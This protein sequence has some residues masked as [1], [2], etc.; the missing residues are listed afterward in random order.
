LQNLSADS[1][2]VAVGAAPAGSPLVDILSDQ[3]VKISGG[4]ITLEPFQYLWLRRD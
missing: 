3:A 2:T 1:Q 4:W